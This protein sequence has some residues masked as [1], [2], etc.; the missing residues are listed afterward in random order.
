MLKVQRVP[1]GGFFVARDIVS[2]VE[3]GTVFQ[4]R[5]GVSFALQ[6]ASQTKEI[7]EYTVLAEKN[8]YESVWIPEAWG[9]DAF[10]LLAVLATMTESI[11]LATGIVNVFSRTPAIVA[12]SIASL[13]DISEGRAI[14]GLG[15]SG[16]IVIEHWHGLEFKN[17]LTRTREFVEVVRLILSG[18]RA[19]YD[20]EVYKLRDF[21]LAFRPPRSRVP[22]YLAAIGPANSCL[23][24]EV[25]DGWLPVFASAA[26][27]ETAEVWL[28]EGV[29]R[30]ARERTEVTVAAYIPT[31]LGP[32]APNLLRR[33][34]AFYVGGMGSYYFR[35]MVRSGWEREA[36]AIR[37]RWRAA[38]RKEA[39]ELVT[40]EML[41]A[42]TVTGDVTAARAR[43]QEFR[44]QG[45]DLPILAMPHGA[46]SGAIRATLEALGG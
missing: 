44:R 26:L 15:A 42:L 40:D 11:Q 33:H 35:L 20:G 14:L 19:D 46:E 45:V 34:I 12:Q 41:E 5:L 27:L 39:A 18:S 1:V 3:R 32:Q 22:I 17:V 7:Q 16:P 2:N 21:S 6:L 8:G 38:A 23:A 30:A 25:A 37:D 29:S 9:R 43:L 36:R 13:D 31:L 24:G 4:P 28:A 10:T